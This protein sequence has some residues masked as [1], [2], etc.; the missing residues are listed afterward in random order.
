[1]DSHC[2]L[3]IVKWPARSYTWNW[4]DWHSYDVPDCTVDTGMARDMRR[5]VVPQET[6]KPWPHCEI[7][8]VTAMKLWKLQAGPSNQ[9]L[10]AC[11]AT[12]FQRPSVC[13]QLTCFWW[14][15]WIFQWDGHSLYLSARLQPCN[16]LWFLWG[17]FPQNGTP[18]WIRS[19]REKIGLLTLPPRHLLEPM[20]TCKGRLNSCLRLGDYSHFWLRTDAHAST[21]WM[22][23]RLNHRT[24]LLLVW[25]FGFRQAALALLVGLWRTMK[26]SL[27]R[28]Y[29]GWVSQWL[30]MWLHV[31]SSTFGWIM[32]G[33][34][35]TIAMLLSIV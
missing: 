22:H 1:M 6:L 11:A 24:D 3:C 34:S 5:T 25:E 27:W 31:C 2:N 21:T 8:K 15:W 33:P 26:G 4:S 19:C 29:Y 10:S 9:L 13:E 28:S 12:K 35:K 14:S 7:P 32:V 18:F 30:H 17:L 20:W 16:V 23:H